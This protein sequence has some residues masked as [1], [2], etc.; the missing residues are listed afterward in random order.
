MRS[1]Y[2]VFGAL[3]VAFPAGFL[4]PSLMAADQQQSDALRFARGARA[5]AENCGRCHNLRD[6]KEF[7]D[8]NWDLIVAQMRVRANIPGNVADD[9]VVF[10]KASN[11]SNR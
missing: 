4:G 7:S 3:A 10:L 1:M 5:W 6:A 2:I 9:I 11:G 8:K